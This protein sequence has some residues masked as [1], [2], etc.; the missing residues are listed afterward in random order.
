MNRF[1]GSIVLVSGMCV[2]TGMLALPVVTAYSGFFPTALLLIICWAFMLITGFIL[3]DIHAIVGMQSNLITMSEKT[4]GKKAKIVSWICYLFIFYS[5]QTA[6]IAAS[7]PIFQHWMPSLP[8]F[9]LPLLLTIL[10]GGFIL[11]GT[12]ATDRINRFVVLGLILG[13]FLLIFFAP[14]YF[15]MERIFHKDFKILL[16]NAPVVLISFGFQNIVPTLSRY[17]EGNRKKIYLAL[18]LGSFFP[19][20]LYLVWEFIV[21]GC[22]PLTGNNGLIATYQMGSSAIQPLMHLFH[23]NPFF[24][25]G[26]SL[27]SF[28]AI[29]ASFLGIAL[30]L[31]DFLMDG[32]KLPQSLKGRG[33]AF[34]LAFFFPIFFVYLYPE[35]FLFSMQFAGIIAIILVGII[36][37]LMGFALQKNKN[38]WATLKGKYLLI[39]TCIFFFLV[40]GLSIFLKLNFLKK[41]VY[42]IRISLFF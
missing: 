2:G 1:L 14:H 15:Q 28:S 35:I 27:F 8:T 18:F 32:L 37:C 9:F 24:S 10:F 39:I 33:L 34:I 17:L 3:T 40:E 21:L 6:H 7:I 26:V 42:V 20:V 5:L 4:I 16:F 29:L 23:K 41:M 25:F 11:K 12:Q 31:I 38:F 36:P 19:L 30:A 13:Y 22:V